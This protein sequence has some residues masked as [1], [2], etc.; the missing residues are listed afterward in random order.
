MPSSY[1]FVGSPM[2]SVRSASQADWEAVWKIFSAV[3]ARGDTF[4]HESIEKD[5][6]YDIWFGEKVNAWVAESEGEVI[7]AY[8]LKPNLP[9]RASHVANASY[10]VD[11]NQRGR[12]VGR[13]LGEHSIQVAAE[14]GFETLQFNCVV[15]TNRAAVALWQSL[16]FQI[17]G[18]IPQAFRHRQLGKV[19]ALIMYRPLRPNNQ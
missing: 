17:I 3:I 4:V 6:A 16:E 8:Y 15:E 2:V 18:K 7:G 12:G 10:M 5:D 19:D 13:L 11:E 9:G 14:L 1:F